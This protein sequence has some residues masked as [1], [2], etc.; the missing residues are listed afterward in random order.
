[1]RILSLLSDNI[2]EWWKF[3]IPTK[4]LKDDQISRNFLRILISMFQFKVDT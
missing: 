2:R 3:L 1:M 4:A